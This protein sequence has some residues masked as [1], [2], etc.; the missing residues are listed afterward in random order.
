MTKVE[1]MVEPDGILN[2][3]GRETVAF[4]QFW[5]SHELNTGRLS[6]NLSVPKQGNETRAI[7]EERSFM[8]Q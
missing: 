8:P 3:F 5:L 6:A 2:D 7:R 1:S 4:V